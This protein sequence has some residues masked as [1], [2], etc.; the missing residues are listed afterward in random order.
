MQFCHLGRCGILPQVSF[1][2][3]EYGRNHVSGPGPFS[4]RHVCLTVLIAVQ[5]RSEQKEPGMAN[6][7]VRLMAIIQSDCDLSSV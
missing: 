6:F 5:Y 1:A 4:K 2:T 3:M 7:F